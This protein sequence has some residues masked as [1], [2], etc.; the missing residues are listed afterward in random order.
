MSETTAARPLFQAALNGD[1]VHPAAPRTPGDIAAQ[2]RAAVDAVARDRRA[3]PVHAALRPRL[4]MM[5]P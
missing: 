4:R 5:E 3:H 1:R 2:A